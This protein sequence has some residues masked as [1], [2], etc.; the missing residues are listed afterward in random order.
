MA[1]MWTKGPQESG[2]I[3]LK[4]PQNDEVSQVVSELNGGLD[5]NNM[6]LEGVTRADL[7]TIVTTTGGT[8]LQSSMVYPSQAYYLSDDNNAATI[9]D[10]YDLVVGWNKISHPLNAL[11]SPGAFLDFE[12][13]EGMLKGEACLD[14]DYRVS[15]YSGLDSGLANYLR[16]MFDHTLDIGVFVNDVLV[17]RTGPMWACGRSSFVVPFGCPVGSGPCHID[18][19]FQLQFANSDDLQPTPPV[20]AEV[21][22]I[23]DVK[24]DDRLLWVRNQYR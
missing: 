12:S 10:S 17:S 18:V 1:R 23:S 3:L 20:S 21:N 5:Q 6:P 2:D 22:A 11:E 15:F 9:I 13:K 19:R 24:I 8:N 4:Q 16:Y 14:F 7:A